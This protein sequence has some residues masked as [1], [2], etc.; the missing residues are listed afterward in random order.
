MIDGAAA[1]ERWEETWRLGAVVAPMEPLRALLARYEERHRAYHDFQHVLQCLAW[2]AS[3]RSQ[4][5]APFEVELAVWYH[6]AIYQPRASDNEERSAQLAATALQSL[7]RATVASIVELIRATDH[8]ASPVDRDA[9][10]LVDIDLAIL[11]SPIEAFDA[12][13]TAIRREYRWVPGP[14]YR[15]KRREVL[16]AFLDRPRI[17]HTQH[18]HALFEA[19]ARAN[20]ERSIMRLS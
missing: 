2:A 15:C 3:I 5:R 10:F 4:L 13:E 1:Q 16:Q 8:R 18:F 9:Q 7:P 11:G 6:D 20:L 12:Y 14:L 17:F 19:A